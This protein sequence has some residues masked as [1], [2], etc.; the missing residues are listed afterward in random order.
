MRSEPLVTAL[1]VLVG[2]EMTSRWDKCP[3]KEVC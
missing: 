1:A 3:I 2:K